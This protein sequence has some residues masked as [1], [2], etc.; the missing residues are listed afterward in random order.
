MR[1]FPKLLFVV[2]FFC[3][4]LSTIACVKNETP[5]QAETGAVTFPLR[6]KSAPDRLIRPTCTP[7]PEGL[8][9]PT[10][11]S[12]VWLSDTQDMSFSNYPHALEDMG[13]WISA[14]KEEKNIQY[15]V[16]TGDIVEN[17]FSERQWRNFDQCY[18]CFKDDI[19]YLP[20]AGNHDIGIRQKSYSAYLKQPLVR[21]LPR[22]SI[23]DRGRAV[24]A[25]FESGGTKFVLVG[26]GWGSE[27]MAEDWMNRVLRTHSDSVAIL[28]F[29]GYIQGSG[30]YT[31]EGKKM[32]EDVVKTN[33]N[34]RIVLCGHVCGTGLRYEDIDDDG[35][36]VPDRR[37]TALLYNY[38]H[39]EDECGQLRLLTF[40]PEDHSLQVTTYSP[41]TQQ[42]YR[43]CQFSRSTFTIDHAY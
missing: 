25:E 34:V 41:H 18:N 6:A 11:F 10:P 3:A 35:D 7:E 1:T 9:V 27:L 43:D 29:H 32:F 39:F 4:A 38:Q 17:G 23:F 37:V 16:Q 2:L 33:P 36:G 22:N 13:E 31:I 20:V 30:R 8:P 40:V 26:A 28:L 12:I 19:P 5:L 42:F 14:Q 21:Q 24:S 15:V